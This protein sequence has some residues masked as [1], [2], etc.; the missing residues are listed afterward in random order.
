MKKDEMRRPME[1][2]T[3]ECRMWVGKMQA[4]TNS[5][6]CNVWDFFPQNVHSKHCRLLARS[7]RGQCLAVRH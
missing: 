1:T 6:N 7:R 3:E 4:H 5:E 2:T